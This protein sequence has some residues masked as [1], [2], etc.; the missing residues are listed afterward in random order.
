M[1]QRKYM[2][3]TRLAASG[4]PSDCGWKVVVICSLVPIKRM[5]SRQNVEVKTGSRS[6]TMD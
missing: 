5:S 2:I 1:R 4:W 6:D 3:I